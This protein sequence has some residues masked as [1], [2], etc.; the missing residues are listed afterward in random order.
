[1]GGGLLGIVDADGDDV[2]A[3]VEVWGEVVVE[4]DVA[5]GAVAEEF[6][7]AVD[8][9]VGHDAVE[10]YEDAFRGI[11]FLRGERAAV[12]AY[13]GGEEASGGATGGVL[14]DGAGDAPVMREGDGFP[15]G[16]VECGGLGAGWVG[17]EERQPS[18]NCWIWRGC[19][20]AAARTGARRRVARRIVRRMESLVRLLG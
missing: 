4:A 16:V 11:E 13:A 19:D 20:C 18:V 6:S 7:V 12:P 15:G 17:L 14:V 5:V 8:V 10:G 9:A 2:F 1:V 3:G